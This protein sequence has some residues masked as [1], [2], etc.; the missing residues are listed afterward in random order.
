MLS[1]YANKQRKADELARH[2]NSLI[3][4]E[5]SESDA[6]SEGFI[7]IYSTKGSFGHLKIGRTG[8]VQKRLKEWERQC[9]HDLE[10]AYPKGEQVQRIPHIKRL[11]A[12]IHEELRDHRL[13]ELRCHKCGRSH[14]EWFK[15]ALPDA[16]A[17]VEKWSNW[18]L[19][20]PYKI[21]TTEPSAEKSKKD[22]TPGWRGCLKDEQLVELPK[23]LE[24]AE[25][26]PQL[27]P[28][29]QRPASRRRSSPGGRAERSRSRSSNSAGR[30]DANYAPASFSPE[31]LRSNSATA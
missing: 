22:K 12:I 3:K 21:L 30:Q 24:Q 4:K 13:R 11:E 15:Q 10:L 18:M 2:L 7:Y 8:D 29:R 31:F 1:P 17:V 26:Q 16:L 25:T 20:Q 23:L 28:P 5:L 19:K 14:K 9:G 27:S 6:K